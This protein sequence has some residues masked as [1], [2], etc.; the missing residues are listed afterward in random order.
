MML[1]YQELSLGLCVS[2]ML[3]V[4]SIHMSCVVLILVYHD[5]YI[6]N[7][8]MPY[9]DSGDSGHRQVV[10]ER[11]HEQHSIPPDLAVSQRPHNLPILELNKVQK[12][13]EGKESGR[14]NEA[15]LEYDAR[16]VAALK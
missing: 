11:K 6:F 10:L 5:Q 13:L 7:T 16:I 4:L 9:S 15:L 14:N 3:D 8:L 12:C 2:N 1:M